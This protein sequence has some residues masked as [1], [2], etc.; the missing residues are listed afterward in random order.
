MG[1]RTGR[2]DLNKHFKDRDIYLLPDN[3][4]AGRDHCAQVVRNLFPFA[5]GIHVVSLPGLPDKGDV[6]DWIKAGGTADQ[7]VD[8]MRSAPK[9][10]EPK[11]EAAST[12]AK[13]GLD[14]IC[15][16]DVKPTAIEW[17]WPN[18]LAIGKVHVLA[19][20]G[21]NGTTPLRSRGSNDNRRAVARRR[22]KRRSRQRHHLGC[23]G[24]R[25]GYRRTS[26]DGSAR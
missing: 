19:G 9:A 14:V 6:S 10:E 3:D 25:R 2:Q 7:L 20:E 21:G 18:W 11:E 13:S 1:P 23:R 24:C 16:A 5:R 8:L 15:V 26:I 12:K 22:A 4:D 17:L